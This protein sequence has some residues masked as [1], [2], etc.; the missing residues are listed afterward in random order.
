MSVILE[1][2]LRRPPE[3]EAFATLQIRSH[4][5]LAQA[6]AGPAWRKSA[7]SAYELLVRRASRLAREWEEQRPSAARGSFDSWDEAT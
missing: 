2:K 5:M 1:S 4:F 3:D 6:K 7:D